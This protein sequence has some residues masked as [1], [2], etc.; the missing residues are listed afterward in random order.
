[1]RFKEWL[2]FGFRWLPM[3]AVFGFLLCG[4]VAFAQDLDAVATE[5]G[6]GQ[7]DL[8]A[9]LARI[10]NVFLGFLGIILVC[11]VVYAGFLWMTAGGNTE[12]ITKAKK[13]VINASVGLLIILS[14]WGITTFI[15]NKLMGAAG[16]TSDGSGDD[17]GGGSGGGI[18]GGD[19][20]TFRVNDFSPEGE[21]SIRNIE[22]TITFN[23]K[24]DP[25]SIDGNVVVT[26]L[27]SGDTVDGTLEVSANKVT[28]T[29]LATCDEPNEDYNCFDEFT[30][31]SVAVSTSVLDDDGTSLS[32]SIYPCTAEF[33]S[34]DVVDTDGPEVEF[35]Y[36]ESGERIEPYTSVFEQ[37]YAEDDYALSGAEFAIDDET[38]VLEAVSVDDNASSAYIETYWDTTD[39]DTESY[40][41]LYATVTDLAGNENTDSVRVYIDPAHCYNDVMDEDEEDVD[42]G[43]SCGACDGD[44]CSEDGDCASGSC[45]DNVCVAEPMISSI[46][47]EDGAVGTLVTINGENF[48]SRTGT[49]YFE[50]GDGALLE[51]GTSAI[52]GDSWD[53]DEIVIEVP[54]GAADG[55]ITVVATNGYDDATNDDRGPVID[56]FEV[57]SVE[58]PGICRIYPDDGESG[59][60]ATVYGVNFTSEADMSVYFGT[61][62]VRTFG[63]WD[64]DS[65][66]VTVPSLEDGDYDVM[67]DVDGVESNT[68]EYVVEASVE[69]GPILSGLSPSNGGIGQYVTLQGSDFGSTQ[70]LVWIVSQSTGNAAYASVAFPDECGVDFWSDDEVIV[71]IPSEY[72]NGQAIEYTTHDVYVDAAYLDEDSNALDFTITT[73]DPSPGLCALSP[74]EGDV[75][76]DSGLQVTLYGENFGSDVGSVRFYNEVEAAVDS[77][78]EGE[79]VVTAPSS[80]LTGPVTLYSA[81]DDESNTVNFEVGEGDSDDEEEATEGG[82][83]WYFSTGDIPDSPSVLVECTDTSVSGV[84]NSRFLSDEGACLNADVFVRFASSVYE[85]TVQDGEGI[86]VEE[87]SDSSCDDVVATVPG[88]VTLAWGRALTWSVDGGYESGLFKADT[89]YQVTILSTVVSTDG[90]ELGSDVSWKFSTGAADMD[91][92]I[93]KIYVTPETADAD[94][95]GQD[96]EFLS[97][98]GTFDCQVLSSDSFDWDWQIDESYASISAGGCDTMSGQECALATALA[99]GEADVLVTESDSG[100]SEGALY[101]IDFSDPAVSDWWPSCDEACTN[102]DVGASFDTS[103]NM[104][105]SRGM[106]AE[107]AGAFMV[108]ACDNELCSSYSDLFASSATCTDYADDGGCVELSANFLDRMDSATFYRATISGNL[109]STSGVAIIGTNYGDDFSWTFG[110]RDDASECSV[111]SIDLSPGDSKHTYIGSREVFSVNAYGPRDGCSTTGQK[112]VSSDYDWDWDDPIENDA[113]VSEWVKVNSSLIDADADGPVEGCTSSCLPQGTSTYDAICG[114][115]VIGVAEDCD[116]GNASDGDGCSSICLREGGD[117]VGTCG[118]GSLDRVAADGVYDQGGGEDCDDGGNSDGD[119]CSSACLN[120]GSSGTTQCGNDDI[121]YDW[122]IGGEECEDADGNASGGDGCSANCLNEGSVAITDVYGECGDGVLDTPYESCD[123]G[124]TSDGDGC[125]STCVREGGDVV[126]ICG[127]G[128]VDRIADDGTY[129]QGGGEDCDDDEGCSDDCLWLGS[130]Y[131]Y[132]DVS[133]CGDGVTGAGEYDMCESGVLGDLSVDSLQVA[134]ISDLAPT[135]VDSATNISTSTVRVELDAYGLWDE[136]EMI[137]YCGAETGADCEDT[138]YGVGE[139]GCC[140]ARPTVSLYPSGSAVCT[141][142]AFSATFSEKIDVDTL[143]DHV[144]VRLDISSASD[145][146]CP[147]SHDVY[148]DS[149]SDGSVATGWDRFWAFLMPWTNAASDGDCLMEVTGFDQTAVSDTEYKVSITTA[150]IL[151]AEADY[152]L[153]VVGDSDVLDGDKEG[154]L[155]A[156]GV[157]IDGTASGTGEIAQ[158]FTTGEG[159][160]LFDMA[161]AEDTDEDSPGYYRTQKESHGFLATAYSVDGGVQQEIQSMTG[162]YEWSWSDWTVD[163][164]DVFEIASTDDE[165]DVSALDEDGEANVV[166]SAVI[167][168]DATDVDEVGRVVSGTEDVTAVLCNNIWPVIDDFPFV[169]DST[170]AISGVSE[171]YGWMN[172]S[173]YYCRD[174]GSSDS[175]DDDLPELEVLVTPSVESETVMKEYFFQVQDGSGD[176]IGVRI[177]SNEEY[178]T[179]LAWYEDRGFSGSPSELQVDGFEAIADGRT[180]YVAAPNVTDSGDVYAN[181][182]VIA[183]NEGAGDDTVAIYNLI[184]ENFSFLTNLD[185]VGLCYVSGEYTDTECESDLDCSF[186]AGEVCGD[187]VGKLTRD[188]K[189][190]LDVVSVSEAI[191]TY[192]ESYGF[193]SETTSQTCVIDD[194]CLGDETCEA[195]VPQLEAGTFVRSMSVSSW[196]SWSASLQGSLGVLPVDPLNAYTRCGE[197]DFADFDAATCVDLTNGRYTCPVGS[198]V[199]HYR[200]VGDDGYQLAAELEYDGADWV[201]PI[202]FDTSDDAD[203]ILGGNSSASPDGFNGGP[204]YC[205]CADPTGVSCPIY[206][207]SDICGDGIVG[208]DE[209]CEIGQEGSVASCTTDDGEG[210]SIAQI[211][212]DDCDGFIDNDGASCEA[213]ECGNGVIEAAEECDDGSYNG[214][215]GY[216]GND[217]SYSTAFYC[218]D[219]SLAGGEVCDCG[220]SMASGRTYSGGTCGDVNGS[221]DYNPANTCAWDCS[222]PASYCGDGVV[223]AVEECDGDTESYAGALCDGGRNDGE[224]CDTDDE[225][226]G[227]GATCGGAGWA[228]VCEIARVCLDGDAHEIGYSCESDTDC[229][230]NGLCSDYDLQLERIRS[231]ND[232]GAGGTDTCTWASEWRGLDCMAPGTCGDGTID[233]GEECDD[234]NEDSTD[235]CTIECTVNV[236]G[237]RY[238]YADEE[239]C[240]DGSGNGEVCS[241]QYESTCN[242]CSDSC[243]V[244]TNSG[245]FCGDGEINGD[246]FCDGGDLPYYFVFEPALFYTQDGLDE[247]G[248]DADVNAVY[249]GEGEDGSYLTCDA[250]DVGSVSTEAGSSH[251]SYLCT[252]VGTC[253]G[254]DDNGEYCTANSSCNCVFPTCLDSCNASCPF[255]TQSTTILM[256]TAGEE[257]GESSVNLLSFD[258]DEASV[259]ADY[260]GIMHVPACGVAESLSADVSFAGWDS[261]EA[262]VVFVTDVSS[263]GLADA[264][265]GASGGMWSQFARK[266]TGLFTPFAHASSTT[267]KEGLKNG[268]QELFDV[269]GS[270]LHVGLVSYVGGN[271]G[272]TASNDQ[273]VIGQHSFAGEDGV[274]SLISRIDSWSGDDVGVPTFE[275]LEA[276]YEM[277]DGIDGDARKVIVLIGRSEP[278]TES[279][280]E[281][282]ACKAK[283]EGIELYT[284]Y[285][286]DPIQTGVTSTDVECEAYQDATGDYHETYEEAAEAIEAALAVDVDHFYETCPNVEDFEDL[287]WTTSQ[288]VDGGCGDGTIGTFKRGYDLY[289]TEEDLESALAGTYGRTSEIDAVCDSYDELLRYEYEDYCYCPCEPLDIVGCREDQM[290]AIDPC[291]DPYAEDTSHCELTSE[292]TEEGASTVEWRGV[293]EDGGVFS[294]YVHRIVGLL[295]PSWIHWPF[296]DVLTAF[297]WSCDEGAD[298]ISAGGYNLLLECWSSGNPNDAGA[299][300]AFDAN[301]E[302][303]MEEVF[304]HIVESVTGL[305]LM[306]VI[307]GEEVAGTIQQ[308]NNVALPWMDGFACS[309]EEQEIPFRISFGGEGTIGISDVT[310][311]YCPLN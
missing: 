15:L 310:I 136:T 102:A 277:F 100:L 104:D 165:A 158:A 23:D 307:D 54:E 44:E 73:S 64:S 123:D 234:G 292:D 162:V 90:V 51:A 129:A 259:F 226:I 206:G 276:A 230:T 191:D 178:L 46:S 303:E 301:D 37:V 227:T 269:M 41:R 176:A 126:G 253:N 34:G 216:C 130:S 31:Y 280:P 172:F 278:T 114:D 96:Q 135:Q 262:Y 26:D 183:Y 308:G 248:I 113:D 53:D 170:S 143:E 67:V 137:L 4:E 80:A 6:L 84:P 215:Y 293:Y 299:D 204:A 198:H 286:G 228:N 58:R 20:A 190:L 94:S 237:D 66:V 124:N 242:Y 290:C 311:G 199:Y 119:G 121:A 197:G 70:G 305:T 258:S 200:A 33:T 225:C 32:C 140:S 260:S 268:I 218:G 214:E 161:V 154:V 272:G 89:S 141:N 223:D 252:Q 180:A 142:T 179:P 241:A 105:S 1:M 275:G 2:Q 61:D 75:A 139:S 27:D 196:D 255:N 17:G 235:G 128:N 81:D 40:Y 36:P 195:G 95:Y 60:E 59:D 120:E 72:T 249:I 103:I 107:D 115:G 224:T 202:D 48:G 49:V 117:V 271:N 232:D 245:L 167:T 71:K 144:F 211:C 231:C 116:D 25:D 188:M 288:D 52:C 19:V 151:E 91:C 296:D 213:Y 35:V 220:A 168:V 281:Y 69:D 192:G 250:S 74:D 11:I 38:D 181:I 309:D 298:A 300:Y 283:A 108:Y 138:T 93:E 236:C 150:S 164:E 30:N 18:P 43:G 22:V 156:L 148:G 207:D 78:S 118:D 87:C 243:N 132:D 109:I 152:E 65:V 29:P 127:D 146:A 185:D 92:A 217:C 77:W 201:N 273:I 166:A 261:T 302:E 149:A 83:A 79:V 304:S 184:L 56:D 14:S 62:E 45:V 112:L 239:Y 106:T 244:I 194:D 182:Y 173:T 186:T 306:Y 63:D 99:E 193:C 270:Q 210:G 233:E 97:S 284:L 76:A 122:Q 254:G 3:V 42:C 219:G 82:Y 203:L 160:C 208:N 238:I 101:R 16:Y 155:S 297:A 222:G 174:A 21:V 134:E 256:S 291:D 171:G 8:Y 257:S 12:Q 247:I 175:R 274:N 85:S 55:A 282:Y 285:V 159:I 50:D 125:G 5:S 189:R 209:A 263:T 131:N 153:V 39:Y 24:L 205:A 111:D 187:D 28:F 9:T 110:V 88:S 68:V 267:L 133:V 287:C 229:G 7:A 163:D 10:V 221:Y 279:N 251:S 177:A 98:A 265:H 246:E 295:M 289:C 169:D 145:G 157:S 13:W 212:N 264:S 147:S 294:D 86:L 57:N 240:D 266:L 47:P